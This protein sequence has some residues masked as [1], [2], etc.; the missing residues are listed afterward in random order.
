MSAQSHAVISTFN[1]FREHEDL[2]FLIT[3]YTQAVLDFAEF[4]KTQWQAQLA[5]ESADRL[6][7]T[8]GE[9]LKLY[10][11]KICS[12]TKENAGLTSSLIKIGGIIMK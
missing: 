11:L 1:E 4:A 10:F 2:Q 12:A 5:S 7:K 3:D 9:N 6:K 8:V